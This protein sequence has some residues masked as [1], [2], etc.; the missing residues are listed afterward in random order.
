MLSP[1]A[2]VG[3]PGP[4]L[5]FAVGS[6]AAYPEFVDR[7]ESETGTNVRFERS[8]KLEVALSE[9]RAASLAEMTSRF[10][11]LEVA[12]TLL[13][14]ADIIELEP[15]LAGAPLEAGVLFSGDAHV[16]NRALGLAL[17]HA[18]NIA[19]VL[20]EEGA[21]VVAIEERSSGGV[22]V[23]LAGGRDLDADLVV[24]AAGSRAGA[25]RGLPR[26]LP[27][28][29]VLGEMISYRRHDVLRRMVH[30]DD[31]Y[32]IQRGSRVLVGAT[33]ETLHS[34]DAG[35]TISPGGRAK[36]AAGASRALGELPEAPFEQWAGIRPGTP[37]GLPVLG[38]DPDMPGL[39][40][41]CGHFRN[42][43]LLTPATA[44]W[45]PSLIDRAPTDSTLDAIDLSAF[46]YTA[47]R[48]GP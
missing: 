30:T 10:A 32:L 47:D 14:P 21:A 33:M 35:E 40:Y 27:M 22:G 37:D 38:T 44:A 20:I 31:V 24:L 39:A 41:A 29:P 43:I 45:A 19:G 46:A 42:G 18:A 5:D 4:L 6:L 28:V 8:G 15:S 16:D 2:E 9:R 25:I 1:Y 11:R 48:F 36:L 34:T 17:A 3:S 26:P 23:T 12:T 13:N 7:L